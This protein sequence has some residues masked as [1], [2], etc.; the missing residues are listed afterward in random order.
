MESIDLYYTSDKNLDLN[1]EIED[2]RYVKKLGKS[3]T[4]QEINIIKDQKMKEFLTKAFIGNDWYLKIKKSS[5]GYPYNIVIEPSE[6]IVIY[7]IVDTIQ[8]P[9][10]VFDVIFTFVGFGFIIFGLTKFKKAF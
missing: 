4:S 8:Y 1:I 3:N 9:L 2:H 10:G 5:S 7:K 6:D